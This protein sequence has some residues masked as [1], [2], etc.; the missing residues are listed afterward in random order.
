MC[1]H[2]FYKLYTLQTEVLCSVVYKHL[3]DLTTT[4][5]TKTSYVG[6]HKYY[7]VYGTELL[8]ITCNITFMS[9]FLVSSLATTVPL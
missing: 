8:V 2:P 1:L 9:K 6:I 5:C 3:H 4:I 7:L